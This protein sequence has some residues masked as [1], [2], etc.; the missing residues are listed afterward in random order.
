MEI[1]EEPYFMKN[2]E[3]YYYDVEEGVLKLTG[4]ATPEA[5]KTYKK[6]YELLNERFSI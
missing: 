6:F 3:W 2:E 1:A 5:I 4:K